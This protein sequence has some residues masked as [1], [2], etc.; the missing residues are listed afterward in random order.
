MSI[1]DTFDDSPALI[2]ASDIYRELPGF[3]ETV[4]VC[5]TRRFLHVAEQNYGAR[6]YTQLYGGLCDVPIYILEFNG[7][8]LGFAVSMLGA[9][10]SA[11]CMEEMA[12]LGAK[13][14]LYFGTCGTLHGRLAPGHVLLPEEA[15]RDEGTSYHYAPASD[16]MALPGADKLAAVLDGL[17]VPYTSGRVWSTDGFYRETRANM[18][19]RRAEGCLAVDMECAALA[20]VAAY[21]KLEHFQFLF[22]EDS[23]DGDEWDPR[24]MGKWTTQSRDAL[25]KIALAAAATLDK[26]E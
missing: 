4:A 9:S 21:R 1:I 5:F 22:T 17:G 14:F 13:R 23:L 10:A 20:A 7:V 8:R 12:A 26:G 3:P 2:S 24:V 15:Y 19:A 25:L 11:A 18:E 16:Y 6:P